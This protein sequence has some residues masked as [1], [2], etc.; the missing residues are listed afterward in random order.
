MAAVPS[1]L[2]ESGNRV[3]AAMA[4][5]GRRY[6]C[7]QCGE[8]VTLKRSSRQRPHFAHTANTACNGES[9]LHAFAKLHLATRLRDALA[10]NSPVTILSTC[11]RCGVCRQ[12][13]VPEYD[14]VEPEW[15]LTCGVRPDIVVLAAQR[16][17]LAIE[18]RF[19]HALDTHKI[20]LLAQLPWIE[21]VPDQAAAATIVPIRMRWH[22]TEC[23]PR[24]LD[25]ATGRTCW[26]CGAPCASE[27]CAQCE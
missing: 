22:C 1:A 3:I 25:D 18:I 14:Q 5:R 12:R 4:S 9:R 16:P 26:S 24:P 8:P 19:S 11:G 17:V 15:K 2:D 27:L 13:S 6:R 10:G 7:D 23:A 21:L 20:A